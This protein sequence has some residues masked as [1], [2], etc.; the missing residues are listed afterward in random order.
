[1][2]EDQAVLLARLREQ[3]ALCEAEYQ[4][5]INDSFLS[6]V[7]SSKRELGARLTEELPRLLADRED[8][9]QHPSFDW[10]DE[11]YLYK[12]LD[13]KCEAYQCMLRL[14]DAAAGGLD[15]KD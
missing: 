1:M 14:L 9:A 13:G 2:C 5:H 7:L 8:E 10:Y 4:R 3:I 12:I 11:H 6:H 15:R